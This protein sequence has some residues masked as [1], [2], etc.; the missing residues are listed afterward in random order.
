VIALNMHMLRLTSV[1]V[2]KSHTAAGA[3]GAPGAHRGLA[4]V[5]V[6]SGAVTSNAIADVVTC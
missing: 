2:Q 4:A 1:L 6:L 3:A 5:T